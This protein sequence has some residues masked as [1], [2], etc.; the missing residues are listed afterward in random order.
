LPQLAREDC[1]PR[2]VETGF[3]AAKPAPGSRRHRERLE[4]LA[5]DDA[6][7]DAPRPIGGKDVRLAGPEGADRRKGLIDV[8]ELEVLGRRHPKL[9]EAHHRKSAADVHQLI[10]TGICGG[11]EDHRVEHREHRSVG[12]NPGRERQDR[13][14]GEPGGT[15]QISKSRPEV[16]RDRVWSHDGLDGN[17]R[18]AVADRPGGPDACT[19]PAKAGHYVRSYLFAASATAFSSARAPLR[20]LKSE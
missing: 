8:G 16:L 9:V 18:A 13:E 2:P 10:R 5:V 7:V 14:H 12:A 17:R 6:G 19:G 11:P 1:D 3:I 4:Q 20:M 15:P